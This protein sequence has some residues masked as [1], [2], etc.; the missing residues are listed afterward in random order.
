MIVHRCV[1]LGA[2]LALA[3]CIGAVLL[4][5]LL[6][7]F[8][9]W[10][11]IRVDAFRWLAVKLAAI[12][13]SSDRSEVF[14]MI[15]CM[16]AWGSLAGLQVLNTHLEW[17]RRIK[18][19]VIFFLAGFPLGFVGQVQVIPLWSLLSV[20]LGWFPLVG[21]VVLAKLLALLG[22]LFLISVPILPERWLVRL[23]P[24]WSRI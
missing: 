6:Y 19:A 17:S 16:G 12:L 20:S 5:T 9:P 11:S 4:P 14:V 10:I 13:N 22:C 15:A 2:S 1:R 8:C 3:G 23:R 7:P 18:R 21:A 24:I